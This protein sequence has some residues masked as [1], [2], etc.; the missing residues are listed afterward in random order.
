M[1]EPD[2]VDRVFRER[3]IGGNRQALALEDEAV[4]V[5]AL[6]REARQAETR[7]PLVLALDRST[8]DA[9]QV[10][11]V[12]GDQVIVLHEAL[13]AARAGV[14][15]IAHAPADLALDVEGQPLLRALRDQMQVEAQGPQEVVR[16]GEG[17]G[18]GLG[19]D[20]LRHQLFH[21]LDAID[22]FGDPEQGVEIAQAPLAVLDVG[23]DHVARVAELE[24][25]VVGFH[26]LGLDEGLGRSFDDF[27]LEAPPQVMMQLLVAPEISGLQ[28]RGADGHVRLGLADALLDRAHGMADLEAEI[29][30]DI[31]DRLDDLLGARRAL[32]GE[33]EQE[34]D[35]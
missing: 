2:Q 1:E 7:R 21:A 28:Q 3:I 23:L 33:Q 17:A 11:D 25:T 26:Q 9:G 15:A 19:D 27:L 34:I 24:V 30:E 32:V 22:V 35:V 31:E 14:V 12:L 20:A 8:E 5:A 16:L 13:D 29:P 6:Q 18:L 10:A 4:E